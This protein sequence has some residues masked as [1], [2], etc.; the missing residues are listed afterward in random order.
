MSYFKT[1]NRSNLYFENYITN[2]EN[3]LLESLFLNES[4]D[5]L[6]SVD[7]GK[8]LLPRLLGL[9]SKRTLG[10]GTFNPYIII[11]NNSP[12]NQSIKS[13]YISYLFENTRILLIIE[14]IQNIDD[15]S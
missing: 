8:N 10:I 2:G 7:G 13:D 6:S 14:N 11:N 9:S 12:I 15:V 5:N 3:K 1:T 4:I